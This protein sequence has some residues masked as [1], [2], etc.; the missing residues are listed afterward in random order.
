MLSF[1]SHLHK[2]ILD[3]RRYLAAVFLVASSLHTTFF[4]LVELRAIYKSNRSG[5]DFDEKMR[6]RPFNPAILSGA[7][8][9][10]A[11]RHRQGVIRHSAF[12]VRF[13]WSSGVFRGGDVV[14]VF[15]DNKK[16]AQQMKISSNGTAHF[17]NEE[18]E[19][20]FVQSLDDKQD[21]FNIRFE[22]VLTLCGK[23]IT[24]LVS[25]IVNVDIK[26]QLHVWK[27]TDKVVISDIDGTIT[28]SD[29]SGHLLFWSR[30]WRVPI[31]SKKDFTHPHVVELL[32]SVSKQNY[33]IMYL[34]A[35]NIGY[36]HQVSLAS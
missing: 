36:S 16:M 27:P 3:A 25:R 6:V 14:N 5:P 28:R 8:D 29:A 31:L 24:S 20:E 26:T 30:K 13:G 34:T 23:N 15:V 1:A 32:T 35:R 22:P 18:V 33:K 2:S 10:I 11:V 19:T 17:K 7:T 21:I 9:I 12:H 4:V